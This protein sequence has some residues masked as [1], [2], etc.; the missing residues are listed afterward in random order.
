M[1][2][3]H[4]QILYLRYFN[5]IFMFLIILFHLLIHNR[6]IHLLVIIFINI[7]ILHMYDVIVSLLFI[8]SH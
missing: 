6:H 4:D 7:Q 1:H 2:Q 3:I 5:V 8:Q